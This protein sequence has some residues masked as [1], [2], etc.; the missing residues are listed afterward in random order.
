MRKKGVILVGGFHEIIELCE[1]SQREIIGII[2]NYRIDDC[3]GYPILGTDQDAP[4]LFEKYQHYELVISPDA[5][6]L[7]K[8][9][10]DYYANIGFSFATLIS[11]SAHV[12]KSAKIGEGCL[13]QSD[14]F[15]SSQVSLGRFVRLNV[16]S[17]VMHDNVIGDY[18]TIAPHAVCLGDVHIGSMAYIGANSTILPHLEIGAGGMVGAGAVVTKSVAAERVVKG[19][20]AI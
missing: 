17:T 14:V 15:I 6:K 3:D 9:L 12:S 8:R 1:I 20:P 11:P 13:I 19:V 18:T 5:P 4:L 7:R 16:R 2:D 10:A